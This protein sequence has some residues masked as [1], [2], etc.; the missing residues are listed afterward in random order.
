[1]QPGPSDPYDP[2]VQTVQIVPS[3][4]FEF[5]REET[6]GAEGIVAELLRLAAGCGEC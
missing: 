3:V 6:S 2:S 5:R 4:A 1:M